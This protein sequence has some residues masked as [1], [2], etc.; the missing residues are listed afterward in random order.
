MMNFF[1][2]LRREEGEGKEGREEEG[3]VQLSNNGNNDN[4]GKV[5]VT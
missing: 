1:Y 5:Q 3:W 4:E 2:S